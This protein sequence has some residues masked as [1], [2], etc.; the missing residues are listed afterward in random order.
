MRLITTLLLAMLATGPALAQEETAPPQVAQEED[1]RDWTA[2]TGVDFGGKIDPSR[3]EGEIVHDC[4]KAGD[5]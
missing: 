4:G 5:W 3:L 2:S 1:T